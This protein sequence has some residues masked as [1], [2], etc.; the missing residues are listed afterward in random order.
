MPGSELNSFD[1]L[2][3]ARLPLARAYLHMLAAT[4]GRPVALFARRRV[5]KTHFLVTDLLPEA[6]ASGLAPVYA[7]VW[8]NRAEPVGA[9][10][11]A[12]EEALDD[13]T[14]PRGKL[15]KNARTPVKKLGMLGVQVDLGDEPK[16][17][18]LPAEPTLRLDAL[19]TRLAAQTGK[20]V[21]L[22][23][24]EV[25]A[26]AEASNGEQ[27]MSALRAVLQK[28]KKIVSAVFTGSSQDA[29][30]SMMASAGAPMYQFATIVDFPALGDEYLQLLC[31]HF[32]RV[33]K[34]KRLNLD[35]LRETY[36][37]L[38]Q[39]PA[40]IKDFVKAMSADG[41]TDFDVMRKK[42]IT[43]EAQVAG[44]QALLRGISPWDRAILWIVAK[45]LAPLGRDAALA[46]AKA[47]R[48]FA[49]TPQKIRSALDRLKRT[50]MLAKQTGGGHRIEDS[51]F[52]E[53]LAALD[54]K[55]LSASLY[56][57]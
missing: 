41:I 15:G 56:A 40:L 7:D 17:R 13:A 55:A 49:A 35:A 32:T 27:T 19:V 6:A 44:W 21:L 54:W 47:D 20:P 51:L 50:G 45:N 29:L 52:A 23:L 5:G 22:M 53:Y 11:H 4:P 24:D 38:G 57:S 10:N 18:P 39:R 31:D 1:T 26:L 37:F 30:A 46:L 33:H 42:F 14:V 28:H 34:T 43:G 16:R 12:L 8:L 9:I 2:Q 48:S 3:V 36:V 25:Q